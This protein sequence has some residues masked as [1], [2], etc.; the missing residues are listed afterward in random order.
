MFM[1]SVHSL[2]DI[3]GGNRTFP[4]RLPGQPNTT[5]YYEWSIAR[6]TIAPDGV[7]KPALLVDN[8]FP[9]EK[10]KTECYFKSNYNLNAKSRTLTFND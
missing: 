6:S 7:E 2:S 5:R 10:L 1:V 9:G 3:L 4:K 8:V